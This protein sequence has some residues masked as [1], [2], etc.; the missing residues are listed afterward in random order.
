MRSR[1]RLSLPVEAA[2]VGL[3]LA[4]EGLLF[5]RNLHTATV[6]DEGVY[7]SSLDALRHGETLGSEVFA[8]QPPGFYLL[9]R[10]IGLF[11]GHSVVGARIGFLLAALVGCAAAYALGRTLA[12]I[13]GGVTASALLAVIPPFPSEA[14]RVDADVPSVSLALVSLALAVWSFRR[15]APPALPA[16]AGGVL[17]L[18]VS[19]KLFALVA[20]IPFAG[21]AVTCRASRRAVTAALG[22]AAVVVAAFLIAYAGVLGSLWRSVV[23]FHGDA[24]SFPS[25]TPNGHVLGHF[26]DFRTPAAWLIVIGAGA[27]VVAWRRAW[28]LWLWVAAT[29]GFLLYQKPL[30][31][32][33]LVLLCAALASAAGVSI[34]TGLSKLPRQG[35]FA[36]TAVAVVALGVGGAQQAHRIGLRV[37]AEPP[38]LRWATGRLRSCAPG[39]AVAS[40]QPI[41]A[42]LARRRLPGVLA[43]TSLVR[44]STPSLPPAKVLTVIDRE[45]I[46]AIVAGR[47]FTAQ[48]AILAGLT[49]RFGEPRR[50]GA[51][52]FYAAPGACS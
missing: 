5:A 35:D 25:P 11:S 4:L 3:L 42:F 43:D 8:S 15:S 52:R 30:F 32:H 40:D 2:G 39:D 13:A 19:V 1:A 38:E 18:A 6:Y 46:R 37:T 10:L 47:S 41:E 20:L 17:A 48:P 14:M 49:R 24:R 22:G 34:G 9:L 50:F 45:H 44:L 36:A 51:A 33:H 12:G 31:D 21:L 7:L 27:T 29:V 23:R 16:L 28:P 26:L